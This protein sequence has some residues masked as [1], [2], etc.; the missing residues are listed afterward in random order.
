MNNSLERPSRGSLVDSEGKTTLVPLHQGAL[1]PEEREALRELESVVER[2]LK[3]FH[4]MAAALSQIRK[5]RLYR[6]THASF[7]EY[8]RDRWGITRA[9]AYQLISAAEVSTRVD[10]AGLP[11]PENER[12]MRE[13][14]R[15]KPE[16]QIET[17]GRLTEGG[18]MPSTSEVRVA[19]EA[20]LKSKGPEDES[21]PVRAERES[22]EIDGEKS[23]AP[24]G[25]PEPTAALAVEAE[26]VAEVVHD[27]VGRIERADEMMAALADREPLLE[28]AYVGRVV[29]DIDAASS[30]MVLLELSAKRLPSCVRRSVRKG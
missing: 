10:R 2:G 15:L 18:G 25:S 13:L 16:E 30:N 17:W 26:A 4:A 8:C 20:V 9:R 7:E 23:A 5:E 14:G 29:Q 6:E 12:Q 11:H 19:V 24:G 27:L 22:A 21:N 1:T 28:A 3:A